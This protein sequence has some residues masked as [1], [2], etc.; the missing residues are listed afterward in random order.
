MRTDSCA[1][2]RA[3]APSRPLSRLRLGAYAVAFVLLGHQLAWRLGDLTIALALRRGLDRCVGPAGT[4]V[5]FALGLGVLAFFWARRQPTPA[6]RRRLMLAIT[7]TLILGF[8]VLQ[9]GVIAFFP[10]APFHGVYTWR[11]RALTET[12]ASRPR[13]TYRFNSEGFRGPEWGPREAGVTRIALVGDSYVFGSGIEAED[14]LDRELARVLRQRAPARRFEVLNLGVPGNNLAAHVRLVAIAAEHLDADAVVLCLTL[15]N[16]LSRIEPSEELRAWM[17]PSPT[18]VATYLFGPSWVRLVSDMASLETEVDEASLAR[19]D[20]QLGTI[21]QV[22]AAQPETSV[23]LFAFHTP[24]PRVRAVVDRHLEVPFLPTD[25]AQ[26]EERNYIAVDGHPNAEGNRLF[27]RLL[28]EALLR[29]A[30]R[31]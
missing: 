15:P 20:Q 12:A 22:H 7:S 27:A 25:P 16:D 31:D 26:D 1:E 14:T 10:V 4:V 18:G 19:L 13:V 29:T 28:G 11:V 17:R 2:A 9:A 5:L 24:D 3:L 8:A 6:E 30:P 23:L 21:A